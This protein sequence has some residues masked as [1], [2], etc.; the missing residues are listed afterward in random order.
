MLK[1]EE[2]SKQTLN[3]IIDKT[4]E[5]HAGKLA[6]VNLNGEQLTYARFAE[7]INKI[8]TFLEA[9]GISKGDKV[10]ILAENQVN[11]GVAY[12]AVTKIGAIL[13]PI[14]KEFQP[15][16]IKHILMHSE[17]R[18]LFVSKKLYD[19]FADT[20]CKNIETV[21]F[22]EDFSIAP[23]EENP[24]LI[25]TAIKE[26]KKSFKKALD[27]ALD[28]VGLKNPEINEND[29]ALL[30]YTS[31]TTGNSKGVMLTHKNIVSDALATSVFIEFEED[32][33]MLS[34]LPLFHTMESTVG[35][36]TPLILG[37]TIY[38]LD[39]PPTPA[40][41]IPALRKVRPTV[42][43]SVP[44]I[45]EKIVRGKIFREI[46]S[47]KLLRTV[48]KIPFVRKRI[49]EKAGK[50]LL[51]TFGGRLK[52][53]ALGGAPLARDVEHFLREA[54]FPYAM[55]YGLTETSPLCTASDVD[56]TKLGSAGYPLKGIS[57]RIDS[58]NPEQI[59]GEIQIKGPNVMKGY[60]KDPERTA[61]VFTDD[62]WFKSG[63]LGIIDKDGYLFIKGRSKNMFLGSNGKNIY[64]EEIETVINR[65]PATGE[66]LVVN[67]DG[68]IVAL[69][70]LN[71]EYLDDEYSISKLN[72]AEANKIKAELLKEIFRFTNER[73][74]T[75][76]KLNAIEEQVE[77]FVK[78]P[79][80]K[81]KRYLYN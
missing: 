13:V 68:K 69:V 30:V 57:V 60:Y 31:G 19:K 16:E 23:N 64:P 36:L 77:P 6:L 66:S 7:R 14:M 70:Y 4:T 61:T 59:E 28:F 65:H 48:Y 45:I 11:W 9:Q 75:F 33:V 67:R 63:D 51:D 49:N 47:S 81:I 58:E 20:E 39:K 56:E 37:A 79:T 32:E 2:I 53:F 72:I 24:D 62:D 18:A 35:F 29:L 80:H 42:V 55:G 10:A 27:L 38:Y 12:F 74:P 3:E 26:G 73:V 54:K 52:L 76:S 43:V 34:L 17:S 46:N 1:A 44:L 71:P 25:K 5:K 50:K 21:I 8:A 41:L 15:Y 22:I 78:T 40:S